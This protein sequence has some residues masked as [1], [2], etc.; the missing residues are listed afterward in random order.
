M[1]VN[2]VVWMGW[3]C[4]VVALFNSLW[5]FC[6]LFHFV[7][8]QVGMCACRENHQVI[9]TGLCAKKFVKRNQ[10]EWKTIGIVT[11]TLNS[12]VCVIIL[13]ECATKSFLF[14]CSDFCFIKKEDV[15]HDMFPHFDGVAHP[16]SV[17]CT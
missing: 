3:G 14:Q 7:I 8:V 17:V 1:M 16:N 13:E 12:F 15:F 2:E 5:Y 11:C 9:K 4:V 6:L 10:F